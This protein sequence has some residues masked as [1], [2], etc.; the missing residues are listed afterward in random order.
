MIM[1]TKLK[2]IL[3]LIA[4]V[5][6]SIEC[7]KHISNE[8][9]S[10]DKIYYYGIQEDI[11]KV[12]NALNSI[13]DDSLS[14][15]QK[16]IKEKYISRFQIKTEKFE[17]QTEDSLIINI[18]NIFHNYWRDVL[19]K[20]KSLRESE[21][22]N[23]ILLVNYLKSNF[24][25]NGH[26]SQK[27]IKIENVIYYLSNML[28]Q[29]GYYSRIDK[30]GNIMDLIIWTKQSIKNYSINLA[31]TTVNVPVVFID[32]TVTLGWEGYATF[33]H[34]YPGGW[35]ATDTLYCIK[36]DYD[37]NSDEFRVNLLT[38]ETQHFVDAKLYSDFPRWT[39]EYRAKLAQLSVAK[40]SVY[41]L[42]NGFIKG[43]END[44]NLTHPFAEY[45]IIADLS[46]EIFKEKSVIDINKWKEIPYLKI[47]GISRKLLKQNSIGLKKK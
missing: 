12:V 23:G 17:I 18:L 6:T 46:K 22:E 19:M 4:I 3:L 5:I 32:S 29:N 34:F 44:S 1:L 35:T 7:N 16:E 42:I 13:P 28:K 39:A 27:E 20:K 41:Y 40:K 47:N 15:D 10:F 31:D 2:F 21:K 38:H 26:L 24:S 30:T 43:S 14:A 8:K 36:K 9:F 11:S 25:P 45:K 33:D 37:I